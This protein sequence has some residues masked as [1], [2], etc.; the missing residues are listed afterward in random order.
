M[1]KN[2]ALRLAVAVL[3]I[4]ALIAI[5]YLGGYYLLTFGILL[6]GLGGL[7]IALMFKKQVLR[8]NIFFSILLPVALVLAAYFAYSIINALVLSL[9]LLITITIIDF[10]RTANL[11]LSRLSTE[12]C[13]RFLPLFYLGLLASFVIKLGRMPEI[14]GRLLIFA[15]MIVWA[16]DT[17]AYFGGKTI[18]KHKLSPVISPNKTWEGFYFGFLGAILAAII[19]KNLFLDISWLKIIVMAIVACF[20]GQIGDL[21]E[22]A[23]KRYCQVKDSSV[24]LPGH[25]GV[26][27]RFDSFLFAAPT[28]Y[29]IAIYWP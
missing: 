18:G 24:L 5:C 14:G 1:S 4:P 10:S 21:F 26:L 2:L 9:F 25:G 27:D 19:A 6:A 20:F 29:F 13:D 23:I 22:S 8:S 17:A 16:A 11:D 12:L 3:G 28:I 7:E 15:F